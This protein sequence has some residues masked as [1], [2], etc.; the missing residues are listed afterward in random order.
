MRSFL[1]SGFD[2]K[3]EIYFSAFSNVSNLNKFT[4]SGFKR[5][6]VKVGC[7]WS[8]FLFF[9]LTAAAFTCVPIVGQYGTL[10]YINTNQIS[11]SS[12][13]WAVF[14]QTDLSAYQ[15]SILASVS[16]VPASPSDVLQ[17]ASAVSGVSGTLADLTA[18]VAPSSA[19]LSAAFDN[20][21]QTAGL[22]VGVLL[23]AWGVVAITRVLR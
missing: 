14:T 22:F 19:V 8:C 9:P 10:Q 20:G 7:L 15:A 13:E 2:F 18:Q 17:L 12:S 21:V 1:L 5:R 16:S 3:R 6:V 23:A 11:C 4:M